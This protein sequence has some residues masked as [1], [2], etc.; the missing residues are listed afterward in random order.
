MCKLSR[1]KTQEQA[2][3]LRTPGSNAG[4]S[5]S[6]HTCASTHTANETTD[7]P[8]GAEVSFLALDALAHVNV[9]SGRGREVAIALLNT[10]DL[11]SV[12]RRALQA[13]APVAT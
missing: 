4:E 13:I 5:A 11:V 6:E 7:L 10:H 8:A 3:T 9:E 12:G 1:N 2:D